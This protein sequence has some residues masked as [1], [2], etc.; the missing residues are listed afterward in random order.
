[1]IFVPS[2]DVISVILAPDVRKKSDRFC[3]LKLIGAISSFPFP[4][5]LLF[6]FFLN[7][8]LRNLLIIIISDF[9]NGQF[10]S[11]INLLRHLQCH[12]ICLDLSDL[13]WKMAGRFCHW[14][15]REC[16]SR[17]QRWWFW[18]LRFP[19]DK[20][21]H[22]FHRHDRFLDFSNCMK[23]IIDQIHQYPAEIPGYDI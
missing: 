4:W 17:C 14:Y 23:R 7:F 1:M 15:H 2:F 11:R 10:N 20:E 13:L 21:D 16:R 6:I 3:Q 12:S 19:L 18:P 22:G 9:D 8:N 5:L